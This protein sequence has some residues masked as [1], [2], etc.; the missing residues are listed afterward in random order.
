MS[1]VPGARRYIRY[2]PLMA[3]LR[4]ALSGQIPFGDFDARGKVGLLAFPGERAHRMPPGQK[5]G[6]QP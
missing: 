5:A 6:H 1:G 3:S 2:T 4:L